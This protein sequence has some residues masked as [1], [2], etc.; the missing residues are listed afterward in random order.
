MK[1]GIVERILKSFGFERSARSSGNIRSASV[2]KARLCSESVQHRNEELEALRKKLVSSIVAGCGDIEVEDMD[3]SLRRRRDG[4][5]E[6]SVSMRSLIP[7]GFGKGTSETVLVE[8]PKRT[9]SP[10]APDPDV[11]IRRA[12]LRRAEEARRASEH[13]EKRELTGAL[14]FLA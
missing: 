10:E 12:E 7:D 11:F 2:A 4:T 3:V 5:L 13:V 14:T 6:A 8:T 1:M 9:P